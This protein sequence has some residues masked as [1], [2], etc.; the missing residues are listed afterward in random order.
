MEKNESGGYEQLD[1]ISSELYKPVET[2]ADKAH[3]FGRKQ[4][5]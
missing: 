4:D 2:H 5:W 3:V 1:V